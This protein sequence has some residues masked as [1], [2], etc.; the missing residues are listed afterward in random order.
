MLRGR[1]RIVVL[2]LG[3]CVAALTAHQPPV[4]SPPRQSLASGVAAI[5]VDAV[6]R[7]TK[8]HPVT[9]LRQEDFQLFEDGVQQELGD[10][11]AVMPGLPQQLNATMAAVDQPSRSTSGVA[12]ND[13]PTANP[14]F[15]AI[16]FDRLSPETR[17]LAYKGA[18]ACVD[19]LRE[20]DF[21]GV[22]LSDLSL[23]TIQAYT[24]DRDKLR[25]A[26]KDVASRATAVFD[27]V[28]MRDP[29]NVSSSGEGDARPSVP[30][31]ASAESVGRP[32]DGRVLAALEVYTKNLWEDMARDEQGYATTN[33]LLAIT[34]ALGTLPGR[35]SVVFFAE[36]LALPVAVMPHFRNVIINA[37]RGNV[38]VYTIDAAGLR[39]HSK[40]AEIGREVRAMGAAGFT[41]LP[42]GSNSS[43][44]GMMEHNEDV[45]RKDPRTSLTLLARETGG[46]LVENT[47][48]LANAFRQVD[49]DRRFYYLLTYV[50]KNSTFNGEWRNIAVKVPS[51]RV[52]VRARSG[53][54]A[55]RAPATLPLLAYEGP[56]LAAL[57]R[58]PAP[59]DLPVRAT[60]LVFPDGARSRVAVLAATEASALRFDRDEKTHTYRADFSI[61]ARIVDARGDIVRKASQPYHL[62]GPAQ[63]IDQARHGE[64]LFFR[65]PA[66]EPGRYALEVAIHDALATRS[67]VYRAPF[68]VPDTPPH[69]LQ[70]SSLVL[71]QRAERVKPEQGQRDNPL[72]AG[73][74]LIYPHFEDPIRTDR[75]KPVAFYVV[76]IPG[77]GAA[78]EATLEVLRDGDVLTHAPTTLPA[79]GVSGR[80][81]HLAQLSVETLPSGHYTLRLTVIQSDQREVREVA[82]ELI[83]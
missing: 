15:L 41:L 44:V 56:A 2:L 82:F 48:D 60:V 34:T 49:G 1:P 78:A 22:F 81:T 13:A 43:N 18:L 80:I 37:N 26:V 14:S 4:V 53:Y 30:V 55:V 68:V 67:G 20:G 40:D 17:A 47:N 33:A 16:V 27:Q 59:V 58:S 61:V 32:V 57:D 51:R 25:V 45:L 54:L 42:D 28:A 52:T 71:V 19:T 63:Q 75:A 9:D 11:S 39:V 7:D 76:V 8:G 72:Y 29:K 64:I 69:S 31:V 65:Q 24:N 73:D 62:T 74:L 21:A 77:P 3:G 70:V 46:F 66:L 10:V 50:P 6:V 5:V 36:G 38:S 35:K 12:P 23:T 83:D 79:A